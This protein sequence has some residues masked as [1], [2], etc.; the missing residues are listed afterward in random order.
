MSENPA[1]EDQRINN[2]I[3]ELHERIQEIEKFVIGK[4]SKE[5]IVGKKTS[6]VERVNELYQDFNKIL[7][8]RQDIKTFIDRCK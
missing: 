4:N 7:Q 2:S 3:H 6:E 1:N 8:E 5:T